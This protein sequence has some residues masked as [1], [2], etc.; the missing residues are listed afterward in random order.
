MPMPRRLF[1]ALL[2][3][4]L[5]LGGPHAVAA[6]EIYFA[7]KDPRGD[8]HGAGNLRYPSD[9]SFAPHRDLLDLTKFAVASCGEQ[10]CFHFT[11][12][13]VT[14]PWNAPEGFY[15]QR[16]D[17]Y[18][19]SVAGVGRLEPL[20]PGPGAVRFD[21]NHPWDM[22][23]RIA[24]WDGAV[25][26]SYEDDPK[27]TG[28]RE[29]IRVRLL[30]DRRTI[31]VAIPRELIPSPQRS[32]RY[33]VLVGS[34]DA[35]GIDGYRHTQAQPSRW[36]LQGNPEVRVVDVLAP[37]LSLHGQRRQLGVNRADGVVLRPVGPNSPA[38]P[39]LSVA[40]LGLLLALGVALVLRRRRT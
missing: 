34:F 4:C 28:R 5:L 13:A 37:A 26:F 22:W 10:I 21:P 7:M 6:S 8:D 29:G 3:C 39:A 16:I 12:A 15:H 9:V 35:L 30:E 11:F 25:L 32:W 27:S 33:Y 31:E 19:D 38:I 20:R 36:L 2:C 23:L 40:A 17:V 14:N 18:I 24:P 1:A